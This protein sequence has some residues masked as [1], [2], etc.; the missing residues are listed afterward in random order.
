[1][2]VCRMELERKL[3]MITTIVTAIFVAVYAAIAI[4]HVARYDLGFSFEE[5][6]YAAVTIAAVA[7][8]FIAVDFLGNRTGNAE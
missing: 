2:M 4:R 7:A 3:E 6:R 1:M 5:I 8:T